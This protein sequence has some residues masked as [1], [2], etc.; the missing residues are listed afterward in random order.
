M[1]HYLKFLEFIEK[2]KKFCKWLR[3]TPLEHHIAELESE[4]RELKEALDKGNKEEIEEEVIDL[5]YD[6]FLIFSW[7]DIKGKIDGKKA[8]EKFIEKMK[9][10]KPYIF[11]GREVDPEEA[12]E[13]WLRAKEKEGKNV[14]V[15][16][17]G[18]I[19][20][21][22]DLEFLLIKNVKGHWDFPKG[23][24][25]ENEKVEEA[26][27]RE[28][29]EETGLDIEKVEGFRTQIAYTYREGLGRPM[30]KKVILFLGKARSKKVKLR[31]EEHSDYKWL[32]FD[33]AFRTLTYSDQK[34]ALKNAYEFI[35]KNLNI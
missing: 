25:E 31:K 12:V 5:I 14:N 10:R 18:F 13:I 20:F 33:E 19:V 34:V 30:R 23:K 24:V 21:N 8:F 6:S 2:N 16:S 22:D 27:L 4:I 7:L 15:L 17:A 32:P 28:A 26:A 3:Q 9:G 11:E 1:E 29:K 35:K